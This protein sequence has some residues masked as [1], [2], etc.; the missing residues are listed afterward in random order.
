[1]VGEEAEMRNEMFRWKLVWRQPQRG[2]RFLA[3]PLPCD[4]G[5]GFEILLSSAFLV[6][7]CAKTC[8]QGHVR[9]M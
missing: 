8:V 2:P 4:L 6:K 7:G 1:M 5:C 3:D 9:I